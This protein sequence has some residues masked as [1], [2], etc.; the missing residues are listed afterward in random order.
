MYA[1]LRP[2]LFKLDPE[3]AHETTLKLLR[4]VGSTGVGRGF[5]KSFYRSTDNP[6]E[7]FGLTFKNRVGLAAGYDKDGTAWKGLSSLGFGHIEIGTVTP[8]AQLGNPKPRVFRLVK[9]E[10][11]VNRMGFPSQGAEFVKNQLPHNNERKNVVLGINIGKNKH[12]LLEDAYL[13]YAH[14]IR[15]FAPLADY[16]TINISSPNT[17]GLRKLQTK[18]YLE[19]LLKH[20]NTTRNK[21]DKRIPLLV[22]FSP[23]LNDSDLDNALDVI[24]ANQI[25][26]VIATNTT[27]NREGLKSRM[28]GE[29][30]GLSG[31]PLT[32]LST[33]M[34]SKIVRRT[35]DKLPVIA[36][37]GVMN[38]IDAQ[39]KLD[40]GA[41]LV[42]IFTG[43]IYQG[44]RIVKNIVSHISK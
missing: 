5:V 33:Q 3:K 9:D 23:D 20:L 11:L 36:V 18:S 43:M 32:Q 8:L 27:I 41:K 13:D 1:H 19:T 22:K 25:D 37:G 10:G 24:L 44:P 38:A 12:T 6:V 34:V 14:L 29:S 40:A 7:L 28:S 4:V 15:G 31:S 16:L 39:E 21:Q 26:G 35:E 2:W 30:G 17:P 42:Q